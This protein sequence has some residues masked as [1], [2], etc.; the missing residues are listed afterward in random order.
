M[1]LI[2]FLTGYH[3]FWKGEPFCPECRAT[4]KD[5]ITERGF[6]G[7]NHRHCCNVC[8]KDTK[9]TGDLN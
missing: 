1:T 8:G 3:T 9:I 5:K 4:G 7:I 6:D 2:G